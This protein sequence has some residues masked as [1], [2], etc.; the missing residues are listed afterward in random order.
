MLV[1]FAFLFLPVCGPA[2]ATDQEGCLL[3]HRLALRVVKS[4]EEKSLMVHDAP[5]SAHDPLFC[6]DCHTDARNV[7]HPAAPGIA[8]CI[9]ECHGGGEGP[10]ASHRSA[11]FGGLAESHRGALPGRA[12]C[13]LCHRAADRKGDRA[14]P[15]RRCAGCHA[16][17]RSAA[18]GPHG[19]RASTPSFCTDCHPPHGGG[20][21]QVGQELSSCGGPGCHARASRELRSLG[22]HRGQGGAG[23]GAAKG[24]LFFFLACAG[25]VAGAVLSPRPGRKRP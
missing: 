14:A 19:D 17:A 3:C 16:E 20:K 24:I 9:G 12:T 1:T 6:S 8:Q 5:G 22:D 18:A 2:R 21:G 4:G 10:V 7:P 25:W 11:A 15:Q 13:P 23:R